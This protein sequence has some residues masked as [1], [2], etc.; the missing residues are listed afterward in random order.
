MARQIPS[1]MMTANGAFDN[2][3][4]IEAIYTKSP[5]FETRHIGQ[6]ERSFTSGKVGGI[7]IQFHGPRKLY[8]IAI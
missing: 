5:I 3:E 2:T 8:E 4:W 7:F 6:K 1:T